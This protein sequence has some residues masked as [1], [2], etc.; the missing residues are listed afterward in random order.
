MGVVNNVGFSRFPKQGP[1]LNKRC[2]VCFH[3]NTANKVGGTIVRDDYDEPWVTIIK[4]DDG[5]HVLATECQY[6][7]E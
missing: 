3:Y 2:L 1:D 7:P 6:S 4:L 5:R